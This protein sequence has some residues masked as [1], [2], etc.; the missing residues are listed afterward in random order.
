MIIPRQ[1][2]KCQEGDKF[3]PE[4]GLAMA[5]TKKFFGNQ[6][7]YCNEFQKWL[8]EEEKQTIDINKI[9][10][11]AERI[12]CNMAKAV[13]KVCGR[14]EDCKYENVLG[15]KWP[16]VKCT[17]GSKWKPKKENNV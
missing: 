6:G 11:T 14:C 1:L 17:S 10:N 5:I 16:C 3:D 7:N 12:G 15:Y 13:N 8:P 4:K 9:A 2:S